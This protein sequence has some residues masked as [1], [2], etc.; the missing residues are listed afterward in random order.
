[1]P[2]DIWS[3]VVCPWCAIGKANL[4]QALSQFDHADQVVVR[5]HSFELDP[6]A[7][8]V[9]QGDYAAMIAKKYGMEPEQAR[10]QVEAMTARGA[11]VGV[12][13][14]FD[15]VQPG[16]TFDAHRLIQ[17][18]AL[19]GLQSEV[20][21]RLLRGYLHDGEA[22]GLPE[23]VHRL[24]VEAGLDPDEVTAVLESDAFAEEVRADEV[25]AAQLQVTGVPFFVIDRRLAV[26]GAQPPEV[27]LEVLDR[28][29]AERSAD[30][31][32]A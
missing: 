5:W 30:S 13:F 22:I 29:W 6:N 16:N 4:E 18:G 26:A 10:T 11:E 7:P 17:F 28:A 15:R 24:G 25:L 8:A 20:K 3:D 2:I 14:R 9:R 21:S 23:V 12:S 27:L 1:M 19:R 32:G 31:D